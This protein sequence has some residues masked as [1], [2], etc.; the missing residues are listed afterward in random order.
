MELEQ[1]SEKPIKTMVIGRKPNMEG[2]L[3][4]RACSMGLSTG[5]T[6]TKSGSETGG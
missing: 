2:R 6:G 5:R 1:L 3:S 4:R